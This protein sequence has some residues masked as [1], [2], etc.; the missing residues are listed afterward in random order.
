MTDTEILTVHHF[1]LIS[2]HPMG[3]SCVQYVWSNHIISHDIVMFTCNALNNVLVIYSVPWF[4]HW[5]FTS[6]ATILKVSTHTY[7][8]DTIIMMMMLLWLPPVAC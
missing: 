1:N 5:D 2:F 4:M 6:S 8:K 7:N 3:P